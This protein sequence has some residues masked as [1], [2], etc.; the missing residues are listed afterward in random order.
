MLLDVLAAMNG[1]PKAEQ[2][3]MYQQLR[4]RNPMLFK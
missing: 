1:K 2:K 4:L 3:K